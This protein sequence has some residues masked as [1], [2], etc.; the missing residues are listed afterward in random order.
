MATALVVGEALIDVVRA[1]GAEPVERPGGAAVNAAVAL[2][3]LGRDVRLATSYAADPYGRLLERHLADAGVA[4]A[5]DPRELPRTSR[6]DAVIGSTGAASY[7]FDVAWR[8]PHVTSTTGTH[9]LHVVS[10]GPLLDPGA[11][12]VLALVDRLA[13]ETTV[14][15]DV[16]VRPALT[17]TGPGVVERVTR[18]AARAD[19]VK[20]SDEDLLALWP[21]RD[22]GESAARLLEL[23][24]EAVIVTRG[25]VGASWHVRCSDGWSTGGVHAVQ[26]EVVDTIGAG[27]TFGAALVDH[28]WPLLGE[29]GR[30]RLEAL[31]ADDWAAA[32]TYATRAAAITV[33]RVGADP[34]TRAEVETSRLR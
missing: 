33:S 30:A 5:A 15:Y 12:E 10:L 32:L 21:E 22:P 29:G 26:V 27:D 3:R 2:A 18:M 11:D 19:L 1:P 7:S 25:E 24:P 13:P 20:A 34:P 17:G 28:L 9:V 16:N 23:G 8:L 31:G 4:L 6:A 14:T